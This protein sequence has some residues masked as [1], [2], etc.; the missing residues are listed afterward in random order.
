VGDGVHSSRRI[1][2]CLGDLLRRAVRIFSY[3]MDR[4]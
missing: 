4:G 3:S 2:S 1:F